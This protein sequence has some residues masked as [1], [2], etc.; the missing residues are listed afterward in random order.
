MT[1]FVEP[2]I[3]ML[4]GATDAQDLCRLAVHHDMSGPD[5]QGAHIFLI[6]GNSNLQSFAGY[7]MPVPL[8]AAG[9]SVWQENPIA[10]CIREKKAIFAKA[11]DDSDSPMLWC[12]PWLKGAAPIGC[13][14]YVLAPNAAPLPYSNSDAE[15]FSKLGALFL[16]GQLRGKSHHNGR[17]GSTATPEDLTSRQLAILAFMADGLVNAEIARELM[18][19]ESTIR[20]ETV[21]IYRALGVGN[22]QEASSKGRALGIIS[23][24]GAPRPPQF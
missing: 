1:T 11:N 16:E 18:L 5:A 15:S 3:D 23:S 4:L 12:N 9:V 13:F 21:R 2:A 20:Q 10:Q 6:D 22:R 7:G 19:S 17:V 24:R 14:V 8:D